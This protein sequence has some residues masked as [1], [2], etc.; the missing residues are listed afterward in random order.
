MIASIDAKT[1]TFYLIDPYNRKR[2]E[3]G[4]MRPTGRAT[5]LRTYADGDWNNNLLALDQCPLSLASS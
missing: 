4:V 1:N 5:Y 3:V 2:S